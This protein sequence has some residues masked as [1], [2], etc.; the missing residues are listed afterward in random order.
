MVVWVY[1]LEGM[2]RLGFKRVNGATRQS[3]T[4]FFF[5]FGIIFPGK[6]NVNGQNNPLCLI[7]TVCG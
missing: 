7:P 5:F 2:I 4:G 1:K 3:F 6:I